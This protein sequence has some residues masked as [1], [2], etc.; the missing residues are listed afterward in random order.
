V[1]RRDVDEEIEEGESE[2]ATTGVQGK[3]LARRGQGGTKGV[4]C[5]ALTLRRWLLNGSTG[6]PGRQDWLTGAGQIWCG[7]N[8]F[9]GSP[10]K[11]IYWG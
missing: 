6:R 10:E 4:R 1:G 7:G 2:P 11:T 9:T 5:R 3:G 8:G